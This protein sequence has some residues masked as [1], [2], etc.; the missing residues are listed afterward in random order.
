MPAAYVVA[1]VDI[2]DPEAYARYREQVP[3]T[4]AKYGGEFLARGGRAEA[5]EG[6]APAGRTVVLKFPSYEAALA[7]HS[8]DEYAGPKAIRQAASNGSLMVVEGVE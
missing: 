8:S 4:V 3:A 2:T 1:Q 6:A 7:W 5:L